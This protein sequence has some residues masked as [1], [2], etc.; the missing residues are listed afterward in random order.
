M[1]AQMSF[2]DDAV[3]DRSLPPGLADQVRDAVQPLGDCAICGTAL[4]E[5]PVRFGVTSFPGSTHVDVRHATC[6]P[7]DPEASIHV[8]MPTTYR[9]APMSVPVT[10]GGE[11]REVS[12]LLVNPSIDGW[13]IA[14]DA[15]SLLDGYHERGFTAVDEQVLPVLSG[16]VSWRVDDDGTIVV[17]DGVAAQYRLTDPSPAFVERIVSEGGFVLVVSY[18][19]GVDAAY[20]SGTV[21][22]GEPDR[23]AQAWVPA[24]SDTRG[25]TGSVLSHP[26]EARVGKTDQSD[27]D[28]AT[29]LPV[30]RR[31]NWTLTAACVVVLASVAAALGVDFGGWWVGD[32]P[33]DRADAV[34]GV[35]AAGRTGVIFLV[36]VSA[37]V[38]VGM[39]SWDRFM[40]RRVNARMAW[41]Y[42][43]QTAAMLLV[44]W[45]MWAFCVVGAAMGAR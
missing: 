21:L 43:T 10:S 32:V 23:L 14:D 5:R 29:K 39:V 17:A 12:A 8:V 38:A 2:V 24:D 35:L 28:P 33:A 42:A 31:L 34:D 19:V 15:R 7:A 16:E 30:L 6:G 36:T 11:V 22:I 27:H 3:L 18:S 20:A 45:I 1:T 4:G 37:V 9:I 40:N 26:S 13:V 44:G 25:G 41:S